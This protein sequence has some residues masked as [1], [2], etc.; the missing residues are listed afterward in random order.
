VHTRA[1][2]TENNAVSAFDDNWQTPHGGSTRRYGRE[3]G[4]PPGTWRRVVTTRMALTR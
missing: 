2:S 4:V 3:P 1:G